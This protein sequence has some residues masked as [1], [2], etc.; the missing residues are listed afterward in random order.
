MLVGIAPALTVGQ[1]KVDHI[2]FAGGA[3]PSL[4][5]PIPYVIL[6]M[7]GSMFASTYSSARM[8]QEPDIGELQEFAA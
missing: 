8:M 5:I 2:F 3:V 7:Q 4:G 6:S 1:H